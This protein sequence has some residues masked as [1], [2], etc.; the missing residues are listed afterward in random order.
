M[1]KIL[2]FIL[3]LGLLGGEFSF[4]QNNAIEYNGTDDYIKV[5]NP[6]PIVSGDFSV[7]LWINADTWEAGG[8]WNSLVSLRSG[9]NLNWQLIYIGGT[10][11]VWYND[12]NVAIPFGISPST[13]KWHHMAL[14][15]SGNYW[16]LYLDGVLVSQQENATAVNTNIYNL[17]IG[18]SGFGDG[19]FD[20][21]MDEVRIWNDARTEAEIRANMYR[22]LINPSSETDLVAYYKLNGISG[23]SAADSKGSNTGVLTDMV[24]NEWRTSPAI[25]GPKTCLSFDGIEDKVTLPNLNVS[26]TS[27]DM[28]TVEFWMYWTGNE[29]EFPISFSQY[30][31]WFYASS[32]GFN[33]FNTDIYGISNT[34]LSNNWVHVAAIFVNGDVTQNKLYING[35]ENSLSQLNS[36]PLSP[37]VSSEATIGGHTTDIYNFFTGK[38]DELR[39]WNGSRTAS[40]IRENMCRTLTGNETNLLAYYNMDL[41]LGTILP[42]YSV[43]ADDGHSSYYYTGSV[44]STEGPS[45]FND[46]DASWPQDG[47]IGK[48]IFI[49]TPGKEQE[50]TIDD[51]F[52]QTLRVSAVFNP[53]LSPGD[54]YY[55]Q[56]DDLVLVNSTAFNTWL[57]TNSNNPA[58]ASNWSLGT[59]PT[60][61]D[62]IGIYNFSGSDPTLSASFDCKHFYLESGASFNMTDGA[63]FIASGN[64]NINGTFT[65]NKTIAADSK[66]HLISVPNNTT[67]TS[68]FQGYYLQEWDELSSNWI[69]VTT[70]GL[71]FPVCKGYGLYDTPAKTTFSFNGTPYTGEQEI[72][73]YSN[74]TVEDTTGMNLI[75][76]PYPSAIDLNVI[77]PDYGAFHVWVP[78]DN[79]YSEYNGGIGDIRYLAPMQG[80]FVYSN[81]N[82]TFTIDN[83]ARTH[84]GASTFYKS[85]SSEIE[86]GIVLSTNQQDKLYIKLMSE[87]SDDFDFDYDAH[88]IVSLGESNS[89]IYSKYFDTKL[90]IDCRP[91]TDIIQLGY[92]NNQNGQYSIEKVDIIG[93]SVAELEDT[94]TNT[95]H[96]LNKGAYQFNWNT[97]DSEERF[98]L[99]LKAT[100]IDEMEEQDVQVYAAGGQVYIRMNEQNKFNQVMIYDLAG[101]LTYESQLNE[102]S[103]QSIDLNQLSGTYLVHLIG[104]NQ[105]QTKKI[106]L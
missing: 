4:A 72:D 83:T 65:I 99:H 89:Q 13:N 3:A 55:I 59:I 92:Q 17:N 46:L 54:T 88:K 28:T 51:N 76:N 90:A 38:I 33:T 22:E 82:S 57:N 9:L 31:L 69:E 85:S 39:I 49:T 91:E 81:T 14:V 100:G 97:N 36:T 41:D 6:N 71:S 30:T 48:K 45:A 2:L 50:R 106:V 43:N 86:N 47:L 15:R 56:G 16:N 53:A 84:T 18:A 96:D 19:F 94:K 21:E 44:W 102:H 103:L 77:D 32:F 68:I 35:I 10:I 105:N 5:T 87:A 7:E 1:K 37:A 93:I 62:N 60:S 74:S 29:N 40:E 27:G 98:I 78:A 79:D 67:T 34:G 66:W 95:F 70:P 58:T 73:I 8:N 12:N 63:S 61:T 75:G 64:E 20:G 23:T 104:E 101:R 25:F 80:F 52:D 24:G 26:T 42:D 11:A